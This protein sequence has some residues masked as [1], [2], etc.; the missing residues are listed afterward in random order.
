MD[1]NEK[2][3]PF[4]GNTVALVTSV[5]VLGM[6]QFADAPHQS[7]L[8]EVFCFAVRDMILNELEGADLPTAKVLADVAARLHASTPAE[9]RRAFSRLRPA[10]F[11][12]M[13]QHIRILAA[14]EGVD[15][16]QFANALRS[17][18]QIV[19]SPPPPHSAADATGRP[20]R[21]EGFAST[22]GTHLSADR[23]LMLALARGHEAAGHW[24]LA[25]ACCDRLLLQRPGRGP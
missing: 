5:F 18:R 7:G 16:A 10:D 17:A 24:E 6:Q 9:A 25:I 1:Q 8:A 4:D 13:Y 23:D 11:D 15:L 2:P 21:S 22:G 19:Q 14:R 20:S 12:G 3:V